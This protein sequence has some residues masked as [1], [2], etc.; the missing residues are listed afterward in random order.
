MKRQLTPAAL[1]TGLCIT[2]AVA[3]TMTGCN[4]VKQALNIQNPS[5][6]IRNIRPRVNI[7][8]PL[9]ASSIDFDFTVGVRNP[10]SVGLALD[11]LDFDFFINDTRVLESVR[12][13]DRIRIPA[14]DY[15]ELRLTTHVGYQALRSTFTEIVDIIGGERAR[16]ELR[17][18]AH[19]DTP[20]GRLQFPVTVWSA[21]ARER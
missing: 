10:N 5:Y 1:L 2:L 21:G 15:G 8:I 13:N 16:Y 20:V 12:N 4:T 7:A 14:N 3:A 17:G 11:G 19:Y 9:S 6:D 18:T